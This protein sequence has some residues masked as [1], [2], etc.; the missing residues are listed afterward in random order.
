MAI[1]EVFES[2]FTEIWF[3]DPIIMPTKKLNTRKAEVMEED[4]VI[5]EKGD[6]RVC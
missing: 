3:E 4:E 6:D 5:S 1:L 2:L